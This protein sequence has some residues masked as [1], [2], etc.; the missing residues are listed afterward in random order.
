VPHDTIELVSMR[1]QHPLSGGGFVNAVAYDLD[2]AQV[3]SAEVA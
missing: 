3:K 1:D 2:T